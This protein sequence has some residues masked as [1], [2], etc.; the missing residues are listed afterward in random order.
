MK[1]NYSDII[2]ID[3]KAGAFKL[4]YSHN[5]GFT[6]HVVAICGSEYFCLLNEVPCF[7]RSTHEKMAKLHC[8]DLASLECITFSEAA[9]M[10]I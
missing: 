4:L 9:S 7:R 1:M 3:G 5:D 8:V 10:I 6:R 2:K